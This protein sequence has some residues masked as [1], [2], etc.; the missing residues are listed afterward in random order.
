MNCVIMLMAYAWPPGWWPMY[1]ADA[2]HTRLQLMK[3]NMTATPSVIGLG[4]ASG[5]ESEGPAIAVIN[6]VGYI[7]LANDYGDPDAVLAYRYVGFYELAWMWPFANAAGQGTAL[8]VWDIDN[9][10][11]VEVLHSNDYTSEDVGAV[12]CRNA[13]TGAWLWYGP[14][15]QPDPSSPT[16]YD[17]DANGT[18]EIFFGCRTDDTLYC[19]NSN[20]TLR[21]KSPKPSSSAGNMKFAPAVGQVVPGGNP[22]VVVTS[23]DNIVM[24]NATTGALIA[25]LDM[26]AAYS[27]VPSCAPAIADVDKDG[28]MEVFVV[29]D[30]PDSLWCLKPSGA[31]FNV[32]WAQPIPSGGNI[33]KQGI[34]IAD[35]NG[36]GWLDVVVGSGGVSSSYPT[37]YDRVHCFRGSNGA[38]IWR[39]TVLAGDVH[40]GVAIADIDGDNHWEV[41]AQ[42]IPGWIYCLAGENGTIQW[43]V[44]LPSCG[45]AHDVSIG[46]ADNDGCSEIVVAGDG[47]SR[48][49]VLDRAGTNCGS[50]PVEEA[51]TGEPEMRAWF[52]GN[53]LYI[54]SPQ[55]NA[56]R[57]M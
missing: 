49:W 6:G 31:S 28:T 56:A 41:I 53:C 16:L 11:T 32:V 39:S 40:R 10:G 38:L 51:K 35:L 26:G 33:N 45:D 50:V 17:L 18:M 46:D 1:G 21:W 15:D 25:W 3:G 37:L 54:I 36:D 9:N 24:Y 27:A 2:Q 12:F 20:G 52:S 4:M 44:E 14:Y 5:T 48:L 22:E 55:D 47:G 42:T 8:A 23:G 43:Q 13:T 57:L 19:L 7:F 34:G 29:T 30:D